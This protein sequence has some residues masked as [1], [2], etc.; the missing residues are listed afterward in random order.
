MNRMLVQEGGFSP[1]EYEQ[2]LAGTLVDALVSRKSGDV[3]V[4]LCS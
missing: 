4:G 2:W 1:D 3:S